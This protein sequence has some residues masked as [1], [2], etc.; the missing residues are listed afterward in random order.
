M[1]KFS[2]AVHAKIDE[3]ATKSVT[4][5]SEFLASIDDISGDTI[6]VIYC[7][8]RVVGTKG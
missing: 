5:K 2:L 7:L 4:A 1:S 8:I 3:L 6:R